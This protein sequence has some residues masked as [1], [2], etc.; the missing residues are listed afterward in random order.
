MAC[1]Y[2]ASASSVLTRC[3]NGAALAPAASD[4]NSTSGIS[5]VKFTLKI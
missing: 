4:A 2:S 5:K 3:F 1:A